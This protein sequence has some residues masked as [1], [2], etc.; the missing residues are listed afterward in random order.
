MQQKLYWTDAMDARIKRM[1]GTG[2]SWD[3]IAAALRLARWTVIQRGRLIG[4]ALPPAVFVPE[5]VDDDR[6]ALPAGHLVSWGAMN[7]GT[8]LA[9]VAW[10]ARP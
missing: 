2:A 1:R 7:A 4:A 5:P 10:P 9:G 6:E 8:V 3:L